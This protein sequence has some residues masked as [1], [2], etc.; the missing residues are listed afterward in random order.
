MT[1]E[2]Y[3]RINEIADEALELPHDR[4]T[5]HLERACGADAELRS[6]VE[7]LLAAHVECDEFLALPA[8]AGLADAL[9]GA[10]GHSDLAG[11]L[12]G[13]YR[14]QRLIGAGGHGEVWLAEDV[15]LGRPVAFKLLSPERARIPEGAANLYREARMSSSLNH[16]NIVTIYDTGEFEGIGFIAQEYVAGETLRGALARGPMALPDALRMLLQIASALESAHD[17]GIVHRD[18]KPENVIIRADGL[19]KVLDFGLAGFARETCR[20]SHSNTA[21]GPVMGT[22]KY[23]APEQVRGEPADARTDLFS[24]GI[25][26]YETLSGEAPFVGNSTSE[27]VHQL[28]EAEPTPL[29]RRVKGLPRGIDRVVE[30]LLAK[31][32]DRRYQSAAEVKRDLL[33]VAERFGARRRRRWLLATAAI[34]CGL[35]GLAAYR[36]MVGAPT[37]LDQ[38][39]VSRVTPPG[40][41]ADGAISPD[42]STI[43]FIVQDAGGAGISLHG[44]G[45]SEERQLLP[46]AH[47]KRRD[48]TFAPDGQSVYYVEGAAEWTGTLYRL[49]LRGG[50]PVRVFDHV[51]GRFALAPD[52]RHFAFIR[53]DTEHWAES[54]IVADSEGHAERIVSTRY[55]PQYY[56]RRGLAWAPD[57]A[58]VACLAGNAPAYTAG[59]F[60][61]IEVSLATGAE[62]AITKGI[63]AWPGS[64]TWSSDGHT[65]LV[66]AAEHSDNELQLWRVSYPRGTIQRITNDISDYRRVTQTSDSR[67]VLAVRSTHEAD[68]WVARASNPAGAQQVS[69]G[70]LHDLNSALP[71]PGG[72]LFFSASSGDARNIWT[73]NVNGTARRQVTAGQVSR[74]E[75]AISRDGRH[76]SYQS[77]GRIWSMNSDGSE[78]RQLTGG[79]WDT[80]PAFSADG[81]WIVYTSFAGWS[82]GIGGQPSLWRIPVSGGHSEQLTR[83]A[84]SMADVSPDGKW[85]AAAYYRYDRPQQSAAVAIYPYAGGQAVTLL[86]RPPGA[87]SSVF[88]SADGN[89]VE[90]VVSARGVGNIWRQNIH[91]GAP[92]PVSDFRTGGLFFMNPSPDR[93]TLVLARGKD[94]NDL[95]LIRGIQ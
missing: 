73:M 8:V 24:F 41:A 4:R 38:I 7:R 62:H 23:M 78:A 12:I 94:V 50:A 49:A 40:V 53:L 16:P 83:D 19:V 27:I 82:P 43:A 90:Y 5:G 6:A 25:V 45:P 91:G 51:T 32:P 48:L 29:S 67:T 20:D 26:L 77:D 56:S 86:E 58:S 1:P 68:L 95:V 35:L 93:N 47:V 33:R 30:R 42:G 59:A 60:Q 72:R 31:D 70:D 88:W 37:S 89:A 46:P 22:L 55:R 79:P 74:D 2:R 84:N 92:A 9:I 44:P 63:W 54:L 71:A 36:A 66:D 18:I 65:L 14:M 80:H 15:Q 75:V 11:R 81:N 57:G 34:A 61:L 10:A 64:V 76:L 52:G 21:P 85:I 69:A 87:D 13:R 39:Q 17:A 3:R 28:I